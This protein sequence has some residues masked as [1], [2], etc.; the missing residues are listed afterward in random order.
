MKKNLL[1]ILLATTFVSGSILLNNAYGQ[2]AVPSAISENHEELSDHVQM[3]KEIAKKIAEDLELTDEQLKKA[4]DIHT[5]GR[6][7]MEPLMD[8]MKNLRARMDTKRRANM[9]EFE[10]ILTPQQKEKFENMK[11]HRQ[12]MKKDMQHPYMPGK[13]FKFK[14]KIHEMQDSQ[15]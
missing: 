15:Y 13:H 7:E 1:T 12:Q 11:K 4:E 10:N 3:H 14:R 9:E 5:K 8:E 2:D 6:Q